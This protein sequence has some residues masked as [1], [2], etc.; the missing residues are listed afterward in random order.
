MFVYQV[1]TQDKIKTDLTVKSCFKMSMFGTSSMPSGKKK[2]KTF[3]QDRVPLCS[4]G[5]PGICSVDQAVLK[6]RDGPASVSQVL[7]LTVCVTAGPEWYVYTNHL[8]DTQHE[9]AHTCVSSFLV[10]FLSFNSARDW[11]LLITIS[12]VL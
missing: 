10:K 1:I 3:P 9:K 4:P 2:K 6:L 8:V 7:E 12:G 11:R 5:C